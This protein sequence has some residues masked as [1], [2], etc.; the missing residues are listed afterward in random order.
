MEDKQIDDL[1][2]WYLTGEKR[3][4]FPDAYERAFERYKRIYKFFPGDPR[5]FE[6]DVPLAGLAS[7]MLR[8]WGSRPSSFSPRFCSHCETFARSREAGAEIELTL[9]FADIRDSTPLA[10]KVGTSKF[11]ELIRRFYKSTSDVLV[12]HNGFVNLLMGDQ[13]SA[14][15]VPRFAGKD[16]AKI[17]IHAA[18]ELLRVTGHEDPRGPW[19]S[20]GV[21]V[22][23]G[24]AYVGT[25]G[26]SKGVNEIAVLGSSANLT[27]RLSSH[28]AAGEILVSD[29][30]VASAEFDASRLEKRLLTLKGISAPVSTSV[31]QM[32]V[33]QT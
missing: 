7:W 18:Q 17:A 20:V 6:C 10:E 22:H 27:A 30:A 21:G 19:I 3:D 28:A 13:V 2:Y 16:H 11:K 23:T 31:I 1:W 33:I 5:C 15:F 8:P 26:S 24:Q 25:V 14:L 29:E 4:T 12:E 9:L 32:A